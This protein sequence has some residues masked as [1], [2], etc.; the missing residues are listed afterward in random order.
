MEHDL[1]F[2]LPSVDTLL[3]GHVGPH[4]QPPSVASPPS[5]PDLLSQQA[6]EV[7]ESERASLVTQELVIHDLTGLGEDDAELEVHASLLL[8]KPQDVL[9]YVWGDN[10]PRDLLHLVKVAVIGEELAMCYVS[11]NHLEF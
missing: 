10:F 9:L 1:V 5:Q 11:L 3:P 7:L 6:E 4:V 2:L 8:L